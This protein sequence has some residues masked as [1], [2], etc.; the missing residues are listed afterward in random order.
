MT[1]EGLLI[2]FSKYISENIVKEEMLKST[3]GQRKMCQH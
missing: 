3:S 1:F 2:Y